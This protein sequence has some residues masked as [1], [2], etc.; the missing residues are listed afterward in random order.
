MPEHGGRLLLLL[1]HVF[2]DAV[3]KRE[4]LPPQGEVQPQLNLRTLHTL[5][6]QDVDEVVHVTRKPLSGLL[7][8]VVVPRAGRSVDG[9]E[10]VLIQELGQSAG[11]AP[12]DSRAVCP[13]KFHHCETVV[14]HQ[15]TG[16]R[17]GAHMP[18]LEG[19]ELV[20]DL[21]HGKNLP[22]D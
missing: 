20:V 1:L 12:M 16:T 18:H 8:G 9:L 13:K 17:G 21:E 11:R 6:N 3:Q 2:L 22:W 10:A 5:E 4:E 15:C 14:D 7:V 19:V